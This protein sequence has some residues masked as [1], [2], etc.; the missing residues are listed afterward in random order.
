MR[1]R[2]RGQRREADDEA[3]AGPV[4]RRRGEGARAEPLD[5]VALGAYGRQDLRLAG[6]R[7]EGDREVEAARGAERGEAGCC[8]G[9]FGGEVEAAGLVA[10]AGAA[11]VGGVVAGVE[12]VGEGEV[13]EGMA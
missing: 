9:Q 1:D 6:P 4:R 5:V 12:E 7:R 11:E 2:R 3:A 10:A 13:V 8:G